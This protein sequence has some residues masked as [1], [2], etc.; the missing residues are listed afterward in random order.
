LDS[1]YVA[2]RYLSF[3]WGRSLTLIA[4]VTLIA[5]LPLSLELLLDESERQLLARAENTPLVVG[6]NGSS[7]DLVMNSLYFGDTVP[8]LL[9]MAAVDRVADTDLALPIPLYVRFKA[10][11]F[12]IVGT[13]LDYFD[14]RGLEIAEGRNLALLGECVLGA[15][16]AEDLGL[17]PNDSLLSS[18][19]TLFDLA[20]VYPLKMRVAGVL[21]PTQSA[22]DLAAFVDLKTAWVIQ[23]LVHGHQDLGSVT[24]PTLVMDR[25]DGKVT[26]TA[27]LAQYTEITPENMDSFHFH[28]SPADYPITAIIALPHDEKAGAILRGRYVSA[29]TEP[30]TQQ[31]LV[32]RDVIEGLLANIFRIKSVLDAVILVVGMAT[33]LALVLVFALSLRLRQHETRTIFKLGCSRATIVRLL[34]AEIVIIL[35]ISALLTGLLLAVVARYDEPLV[36]ALFIR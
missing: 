19:E 4:C 35:A 30:E 18:P 27:K 8:D 11:G 1:F 16:A 15:R 31:I 33:V 28:G 32:P 29:G 3:N 12:P 21:A 13:N 36:R 7:L 2:W 10:R 23:G 9:S 14:F 22:D 17:G 34:G 6:A 24:D 20:G 25:S 5:V 26:A